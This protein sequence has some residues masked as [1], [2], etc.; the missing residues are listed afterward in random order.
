M[1][2]ARTVGARDVFGTC[3]YV[4]LQ[5]VF[6]HTNGNGRLFNGEKSSEP[7]AFVHLLRFVNLHAF[8]EREQ[9]PDLIEG[10]DIQFA[11]R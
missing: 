7:A 3:R 1:H 8:D 6:A 11:G 9:I 5:F 2:E 10:S 4:I